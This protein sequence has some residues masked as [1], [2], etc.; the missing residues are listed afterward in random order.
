M[1]SEAKQSGMSCIKVPD[2]FECLYVCDGYLCA[3]HYEVKYC[4]QNCIG[5]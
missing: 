4:V 2:V 5:V 1:S 3:V